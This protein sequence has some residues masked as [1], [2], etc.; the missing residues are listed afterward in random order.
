MVQGGILQPPRTDPNYAATFSGTATAATS[1][2]TTTATLTG[3]FVMII[4]DALFA[5]S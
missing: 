3:A 1:T 5:E 2:G 4:N